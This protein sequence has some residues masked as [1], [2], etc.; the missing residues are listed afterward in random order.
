[1]SKR[2]ISSQA[3]HTTD[4]LKY[5]PYNRFSPYDGYYLKQANDIFNFLNKPGTPFR[6]VFQRED[7]KTLAVVLTC[8]FED[9]VS[10]IG[11]WRAV[12][13]KQEE[14]FGRPVPF[15]DLDG[16]DPEYLN[17]QDF[18]YL[19]WHQMSKIAD[20]NLVP[21]SLPILEVAAYCYT[22]FEA[23]ID[24]APTTEFYDKWLT[25][26]DDFD[27]FELKNRVRWL[28]LE[29]YLLTP[30]F[31]IGLNEKLDEVFSQDQFGKFDG[32]D[33]GK[34]AYQTQ[35]DFFFLTTSSWCGLTAAQWFAEMAHC[36]TEMKADIR[37]LHHQVP[38]YFI[39]EDEDDQYYY[40]RYIRN[41]RRFAIWS[42][43]ITFGPGEL[44]PGR[45]F[46]FFTIVNWLGKW[47]LSGSFL[48]WAVDS[49]FMEEL[50]NDKKP[51]H[52][53]AWD[54]ERQQ[55]IRGFNNSAEAAFIEYFGDRMVF[56][57][58]QNEMNAALMEQY[59]WYNE[60]KV[61]GKKKSL[62]TIQTARYRN[63]DLNTKD[64]VIVFFIP[65]E[66][67]RVFTELF[68]IIRLLKA[69]KLNEIEKERLFE[70]IFFGC[71][72]DVVRYLIQHYPSKN[73]CFPMVEDPD[74]VIENLEFFL[75]FFSARGFLEKVPSMSL[76]DSSS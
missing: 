74:F 64:G 13:R 69:D 65:E 51:V 70:D 16:Y 61:S 62:K 23:R 75:R 14:L 32:M 50:K 3:I 10:D 30:E 35:E 44:V 68:E 43:S 38:G 28:A 58:D 12:V 49:K 24:E 2:H 22:F 4:W 25:L 40:F 73:L 8:H 19:I 11:I 53:Y 63:I 20:K 1:M 48:G 31:A 67:I 9:F 60:V 6:E 36:S 59:E 18:A 15:F 41:D 33:M 72:P 26:S 52:F 54:E 46:G 34:L 66:G 55:K 57:K 56:F 17:V 71:P 42:D 39:F 5:H 7:L 29:C 37:N 47:W 76:F 27:F 45:L 21:V